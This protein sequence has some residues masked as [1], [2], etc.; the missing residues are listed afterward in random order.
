[1]YNIVSIVFL[2]AEKNP[3]IV[4]NLNEKISSY[5]DRAEKLIVE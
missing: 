5:V 1:M 3:Y 4:R 2:L